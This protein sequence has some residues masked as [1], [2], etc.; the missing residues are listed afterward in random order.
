MTDAASAAQSGR[1]RGQSPAPRACVMGHPIAQSRS[2]MLHGYWLASLGLPG[3]YERADVPPDGFDAFMARFL[4]DGFVGGNVTAPHKQAAFRAMARLDPVATEIGA[5]NTIWV[6]NGEL[7]GGNTDAHGFIAN[8][9]DRAPGWEERAGRAVL[10]GA[11][12]AARAAIVAL[13][14]RGLPIVLVNRTLDTATELAAHFSRF[15][16][17]EITA[18]CWNELPSVL[19]EADLLVNTTVLGMLGKPAMTIDL[20]PLK[21]SA[22]VYDLVY[23]PLDTG[24]L[25]AARARGHCTVD[26]LGMLLHQ[27]VP[28]FTKWFGAEPTVTAELRA[29]IEADIRATTSGA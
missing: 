5:V 14:A 23:V 16:G 8:L 2:P 10:L 24:L 15:S 18:A 7:V 12:G 3:S 29:L 27:A 11:G 20:S 25:R 4:A 17:P 19:E 22:T 21:P 13:R 1:H 28:G 26:G 6:E 9:D